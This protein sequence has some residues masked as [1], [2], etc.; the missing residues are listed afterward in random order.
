[1]YWYLWDNALHLGESASQHAI[2]DCTDPD[3]K[4]QLRD[5]KKQLCLLV[6]LFVDTK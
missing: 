2:D 3:E 4:K 6:T 5:E 1:M